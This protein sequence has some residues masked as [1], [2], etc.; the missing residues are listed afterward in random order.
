VN[1]TDSPRILE[2]EHLDNL[3]Y[4]PQWQYGTSV[5][6][7]PTIFP[8]HEGHKDPLFRSMASQFSLCLYILLLYPRA[9]MMYIEGGLYLN[10]TRRAVN[11]SR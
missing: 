9:E 11:L 7:L 5:I 10:I 4:W 8:D 3:R 6:V 1:E 2:Q